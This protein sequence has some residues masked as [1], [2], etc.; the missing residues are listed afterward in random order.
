MKVA[1]PS[2]RALKVLRPPSLRSTSLFPPRANSRS[3]DDR[4]KHRTRSISCRFSSTRVHSVFVPAS[5]RQGGSVESVLNYLNK[6]E[7]R[8]PKNR[9]YEKGDVS[10]TGLASRRGCVLTANACRPVGTLRVCRPADYLPP[11]T[12]GQWPPV[13]GQWWVEQQGCDPGTGYAT[14]GADSKLPGWQPEENATQLPRKRGTLEPAWVL[15]QGEASKTPV[16]EGEGT[17]GPWRRG[18]TGCC[19]LSRQLLARCGRARPEHLIRLSVC[20]CSCLAEA[21][22][23]GHRIPS[24]LKLAMAFRSVRRGFG[25][26]SSL[27]RRESRQHHASHDLFVAPEGQG[28]IVQASG[29]QVRRLLIAEKASGKMGNCPAQ[30]CTSTKWSISPSRCGDHR[31]YSGMDWR[32]SSRRTWRRLRRICLTVV[33]RKCCYFSPR[34]EIA[35]SR[36]F[37]S[38]SARTLESA[39]FPGFFTD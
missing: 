16:C 13:T 38:V 37:P 28:V 15:H 21:D 1:T 34:G 14:M 5:S 20:I 18:A 7:G 22:I 30:Y 33:Y 3:T 39:F 29:L 12:V 27:G 24:F 23:P 11:G 8:R 31:Q 9:P 25:G 26:L 10:D 17:Q 2:L 35:L 32:M 19:R 6:K 4:E 36:T